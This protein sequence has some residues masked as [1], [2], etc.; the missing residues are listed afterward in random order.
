M[1]RRELGTEEREVLSVDGWLV[2]VLVLFVPLGIVE[3]CAAE[4]ELR[5]TTGRVRSLY[6]MELLP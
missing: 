6:R 4:R 3:R 1:S 5:F 2:P